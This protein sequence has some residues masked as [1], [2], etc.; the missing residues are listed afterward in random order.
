MFVDPEGLPPRRACDHQ[1][2][3]IEGAQPV[4]VRPYRH[5]PA[6]KDE[7]E[8]QVAELLKSGI[9]QSRTSAFASPAILVQKKDLTWRM[10]ID[11]RRLNNLTIPRKFP[12][13]VLDELVDELAGAKRFSKLD[14]RAGYHQI[15]LAPGEEPKTAFLTHSG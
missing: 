5:T 8:K 7:I 10:C 2:P 13:P 3:L 6:A 1:I 15:R 11:Y 9:I 4:F 12:L 14:L